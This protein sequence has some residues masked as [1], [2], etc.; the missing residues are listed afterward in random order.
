MIGQLP[1]SLEIGGIS[2]KI[3]ADFRNILNI[4]VAFNDP[5][6]SNAE[7]C[8]ICVKNLYDDFENIPPEH[9]QTAVNRAYWFV[10][11]GD[12]MQKK[13]EGNSKLIDWEQDEFLIFSAVNKSAGFETRAVEFLH[14]WT[15]LGYFSAVGECLFSQVVH[16]RDKKARGKKLEKWENEFLCRNKELIEIRRKYTKEEIAKEQALLARLGG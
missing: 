12:S 2:Y 7:K 6:L 11:G 1:E 15:F 9:L 16:I 3:D 4:F 8:Y 14:W 10:S 13:S 5:E